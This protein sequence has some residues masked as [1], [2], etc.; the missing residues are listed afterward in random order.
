MQK[1]WI[2]RSEGALISF[3]IKDSDKVLDVFTTRAD[4]VFGVTAMVVAPEHPYLLEL[5]EGTEQEEAVKAYIEEVSHKN[6]IERTS[7][8][9]EKTG[10]FTGRYTINPLNGKEVPIYVSDYVLIGYGTGAIM[11]VPAHDQRD[12][13]FAK[14]FGIDIIPV[15]EPADKDVDVNNLKEAFA[16][17]GK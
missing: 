4:T 16:A 13:D 17:E 5:V 7:T 12:F 3:P 8:T 15:V 1:N 6:D 9:N 14:K 2:G 11:V 10:V